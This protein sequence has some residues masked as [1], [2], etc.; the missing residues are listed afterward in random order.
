MAAPL[1]QAG[2]FTIYQPERFSSITKYGTYTALE[3]AELRVGDIEEVDFSGYS[4]ESMKR[5]KISEFGVRSGEGR[6]RLHTGTNHRRARTDIDLDVLK[7][8]QLPSHYEEQPGRLSAQAIDVRA[9]LEAFLQRR[10]TSASPHAQ[11]TS[12]RLDY[13]VSAMPGRSPGSG[14]RKREHSSEGTNVLGEGSPTPAIRSVEDSEA[15][16]VRLSASPNTR[17]LLKNSTGSVGKI[18][19]LTHGL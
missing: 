19:S 8:L 5:L 4:P 14:K 17:L 11:R 2:D 3:A 9:S 12:Q 13:A 18:K 10:S 6:P 15:L 1:R 16:Y 7:S